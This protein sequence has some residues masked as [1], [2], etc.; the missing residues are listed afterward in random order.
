MQSTES[1]AVVIGEFVGRDHIMPVLS[2]Y[3]FFGQV[4][5]SSLLKYISPSQRTAGHFRPSYHGYGQLL[6]PPGES[7]VYVYR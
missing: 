3:L 7:P 1:T 5:T 4:H 6:G 2:F